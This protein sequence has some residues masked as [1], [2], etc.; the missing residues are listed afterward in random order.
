[1]L[2]QCF[3]SH[4][5]EVIAKDIREGKHRGSG[6]KA[7]T[8][9]VPTCVL[10]HSLLPSTLDPAL[11]ALAANKQQQC[12]VRCKRP[13]APNH[14]W[15][16]ASF[17]IS[18]QASCNHVQFT[19]CSF[20]TNKIIWDK[21]NTVNRWIIYK[22]INNLGR[23]DWQQLSV[24]CG[25]LHIL[26]KCVAYQVSQSSTCLKHRHRRNVT[27]HHSF[28]VTSLPFGYLNLSIFYH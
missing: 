12:R 14:N 22:E 16:L 6:S 17:Q 13:P 1:M 15:P 9:T 26:H 11:G 23:R 3:H 2:I 28:S 7:C 5:S 20:C 25:N 27:S 10:S 19:C 24:S 21:Y 4:C 18:W 8:G